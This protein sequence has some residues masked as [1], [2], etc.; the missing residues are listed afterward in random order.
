MTNAEKFTEVFG[1]E[2]HRD[3]A[4]KSWWEQEYKE[5]QK[6]QCADC[7]HYGKLSLDCG[8]CDDYCS[9]FEPQESEDKE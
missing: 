2:L 7:N 3:Y 6:K 9:M 4:T 5:P 8:R 1:T